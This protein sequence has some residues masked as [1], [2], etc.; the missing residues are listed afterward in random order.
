[1]DPKTT[2]IGDLTRIA[3]ERGKRGK[4]ATGQGLIDHTEASVVGRAGTR[5]QKMR[6][7]A[8][9]TPD[10]MRAELEAG[11]PQ[12]VRRDARARYLVL[13]ER[14]RA[15]AEKS[16]ALTGQVI[17]PQSLQNELNAMGWRAGNPDL[18]G[19]VEALAR[20]MFEKASH[21]QAESDRNKVSRDWH[22]HDNTSIT[23]STAQTGG[24]KQ[25]G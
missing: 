6:R 23:I 17:W 3:R 1:M 16:V 21:Q 15:E 5:N 2:T 8:Q 22:G 7:F 9:P 14:L 13:L 12:V 19:Q 25:K 4:V 11:L 24:A 10:Q 18:A 20:R